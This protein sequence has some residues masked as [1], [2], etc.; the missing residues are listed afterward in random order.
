MQ[1]KITF[2]KLSKQILVDMYIVQLNNAISFFKESASFINEIISQEGTEENRN[3]VKEMILF[4]D[5]AV[6]A[7]QEE[8]KK[9]NERKLEL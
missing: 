6:S 2:D 3:S 9:I 7:L 4:F 8:L 5:M 1:E